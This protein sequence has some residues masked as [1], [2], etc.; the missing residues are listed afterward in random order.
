MLGILGLLLV[1]PLEVFR[2]GKPFEEARLEAQIAGAD[3]I[4]AGR[5]PAAV[6][7]FLPG[8]IVSGLGLR[9]AL[10][11]LLLSLVGQRFLLFIVDFLE[12]VRRA[13]LEESAGVSQL[14]G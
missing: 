4:L 9:F 8:L 2:G 12:I 14:L 6:A 3:E 10:I 11:G 13:G 1:H 7:I 5:I